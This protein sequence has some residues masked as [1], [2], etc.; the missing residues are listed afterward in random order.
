MNKPAILSWS[1][2]V[3]VAAFLILAPDARSENQILPGDGGNGAIYTQKESHSAWEKGADLGANAAIACMAGNPIT[4]RT[5][6]A[7]A[8][9]KKIDQCIHDK[10]ATVGINYERRDP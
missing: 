6:S 10:L 9:M 5:K 2:I 7:D 3:L 1:I 4:K 8:Y